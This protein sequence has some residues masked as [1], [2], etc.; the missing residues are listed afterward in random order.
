VRSL[1][2]A[3]HPGGPAQVVLAAPDAGPAGTASLAMAFLAAGADQVIAT[4][5]PVSQAT[6]ERFAE[7]LYRAD[8]GDLARALARIQT[9]GGG[10]DNDDWL[11]FAAFGR[12]TCNPQP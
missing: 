3:G 10:D 6:I 1:E 8:L 2:I 9:A 4:V 12:A 7:R 11:G 5:R